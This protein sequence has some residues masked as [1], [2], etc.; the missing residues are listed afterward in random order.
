MRSAMHKQNSSITRYCLAVAVLFAL[1]LAFAGTQA[2]GYN[3][4]VFPI[5]KDGEAQQ[6]PDISGNIVVWQDHRGIYGSQTYRNWDIY[7]YDL[8]TQTE[9][10][11]CKREGDQLYPAID[12]NIVV[13]LNGSYPPGIYGYD[14]STKTEFP[15]CMNSVSVSAGSSPSI[16]GNIVVWHDSRNGQGPQGN[17]D[18]YGYDLA[19]QTEFPI[20]MNDANQFLPKVAGNIVVWKDYRN[21]K[22][23]N[24]AIYG[25]DLSTQT[26]FPICTRSGLK[27]DPATDGNIVVWVS[28][29]KFQRGIYG[30][31]PGIVFPIFRETASHEYPDIDGNIIVWRSYPTYHTQGIYGFDLSEWSVFPICKGWPDRRHPAISGNIV[32]WAEERNSS[33][34]I[35]GARLEPNI[36]PSCLG[37]PQM[38]FNGDCKVDFADFAL[39]AQNWLE[40]NLDPPSACWE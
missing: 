40:C 30:Y 17:T 25:Y 36:G 27:F 3:V 34:D 4:V 9:F 23:E 37:N 11:I 26:E 32:V 14:M 5:C 19:T 7:G 13:Y 31:A 1:V 8:S 20:C 28:G 22:Y 16:S 12:G 2:S 15:I 38:D 21:G 18:I 24:C 35:Y 6:Y 33:W 29:S 10:P 39:F